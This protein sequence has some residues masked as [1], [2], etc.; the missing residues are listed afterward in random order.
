MKKKTFCLGDVLSI[1]T[2]RLLSPR[3]IE[4]VYDILNFMTDDN[5]FTHQLPRASKKCAP[6][7]LKQFPELEQAGS[8]ENTA[9]L[10][11]L[12]ADAE[13]RKEPPENAITMWLKWMAEPGTCNLKK[14]YKV[15]QIPAT[16]H[17][18]KHPIAEF[19]EMVGSNNIVVVNID[20][21]KGEG[22]SNE[23]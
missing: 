3:H 13:H 7:L 22:G 10:D 14:T 8:V 9:R 17:Q 15:A 5:L 20:S 16:A 11:E 18:I 23:S 1:T 2:G 21:Q 19:G 4:G 6:F 12:L